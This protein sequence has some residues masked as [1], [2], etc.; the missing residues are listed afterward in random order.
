[1]QSWPHH[2]WWHC[3]T[4]CY[5]SYEFLYNVYVC[6]SNHVWVFLT[7]W[8]RLRPRLAAM[9]MFICGYCV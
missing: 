6:W 5:C 3:K 4:I 9:C 2:N 7:G 8:G 1:L